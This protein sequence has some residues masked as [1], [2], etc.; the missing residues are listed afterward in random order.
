MAG[1]DFSPESRRDFLVNLYHKIKG[2]PFNGPYVVNDPKKH[3]LG[4]YQGV[5]DELGVKDR[6]NVHNWVNHGFAHVWKPKLLE[7]CKKYDLGPHPELFTKRRQNVPKE[8]T[9]LARFLHNLALKNKGFENFSK[10]YGIPLSTLGYM[11]M[12]KKG[13]LRRRYIPAL[14]RAAF[15]SNVPLPEGWPWI[16]QEAAEKSNGEEPEQEHLQSD[17][18]SAT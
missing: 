14:E 5:A 12:K 10:R 7:V 17:Q 1:E 18:E 13:H 6:R 16:E 11:R 15:M 8:T 9:P 3:L 2:V 4:V